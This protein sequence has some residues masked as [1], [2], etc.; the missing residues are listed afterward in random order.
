MNKGIWYAIAAY[1]VWGVLPLY[2]K[3]LHAVPSA[4]IMMHRVVWSFLFLVVLISLRREWTRLRGEV[5]TRI[6]LS[7]AAAG[8]LLGINWYAYIWG[9]NAGFVI[10]TSLG[11][12]INPLVSVVLGVVFFK[13]N[14]TGR[15]WIPI[16]LAALGVLYLTF[17]YGQFPWLAILLALTFG[18]YGLIKK[19]APL[20]SLYGVTLETLTLLLPSLGYLLFVEF[21]G[22]GAFGHTGI[23]TLVLLVLTGVVTSTP[24]L[25]FAKAAHRIPLSMV[26]ILQYISPSLQFLIGLYIFKE[27]FDLHRLIG[28]GMIW[29][30][31]AI[32]SAGGWIEKRKA[33]SEE[34]A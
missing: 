32:Y 17:S 23:T 12:F 5:T 2:W 20:G 8:V 21:R 6:L 27:S 9:V 10:E 14:L 16:G 7:Y 15:Q 18:F 30:A 25:L 28:F 19:L 24:L 4:Q 11:Y 3:A 22:E 13:E 29:V 1:G 34:A 26:G 33:A 31:L